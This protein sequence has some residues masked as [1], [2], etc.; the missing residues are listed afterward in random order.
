MELTAQYSCSIFVTQLDTLLVIGVYYSAKWEVWET[1]MDRM[2]NIIHLI[3]NQ[4]YQAENISLIT[5]QTDIA[6][7]AVLNILSNRN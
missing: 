1:N 3:Y 7:R 6:L 5:F 4:Y 2:F